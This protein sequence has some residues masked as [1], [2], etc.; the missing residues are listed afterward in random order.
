MKLL[1]EIRVFA[2]RTAILEKLSQILSFYDNLASLFFD[3]SGIAGV[4]V[5]TLRHCRYG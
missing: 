2:G 3:A 5:P 4:T 1:T